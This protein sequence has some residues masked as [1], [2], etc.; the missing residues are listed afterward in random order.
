MSNEKLGFLRVTGWV[1]LGSRMHICGIELCLCAY[2][3]CF[4]GAKPCIPM[5]VSIMGSEL[6]R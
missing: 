5:N 3:L 1:C 2:I 4:V 6:I